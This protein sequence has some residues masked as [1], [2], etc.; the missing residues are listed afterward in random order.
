MKVVLF[1]EA[2]MRL[3]APATQRL[4]HATS[5][6][7]FIGGAELNT[8][9]SLANFGAASVFVTKVPEHALGDNVVQFLNGFG[10][11]TSFIVR[12]GERLGLYYYEHG[13]AQRPPEIVYDRKQASINDI[14]P[15]YFQWKSLLHGAEWFH[16]TGI[17]AAL[18]EEVRTV[19][20]QAVH[21]AKKQGITVSCDL[22]YR[23]KL[24][25]ARD[26]QR[27]MQ[28]L[29]KHVDFCMTNESDAE[30]VLGMASGKGNAQP[31]RQIAKIKKA[32]GFRGVSI[33]L[34][35]RVSDVFNRRSAVFI[36]DKDCKTPYRSRLY[37]MS[38]AEHIGG[39][40]AFDAGLIYGLMTKKSSKDAV[41][42]AVAASVLKQ[43]IIGDVNRVNAKEVDALMKRMSGGGR[44]NR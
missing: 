5:F 8:A 27:I 29:M 13:T 42:F 28:P 25:S 33:T 2:L 16:F 15:S 14:E 26:A 1:G 32:F 40:D 9:V 44:V 21:E 31:E 36:D 10:V 37:D 35:D 22:N 43:S 41:E 39:G 20:Y 24:W 34:R 23:A 19:L 4:N 30:T 18:S 12:G 38:I 6:D 3:A 7:A 17:T 11:D